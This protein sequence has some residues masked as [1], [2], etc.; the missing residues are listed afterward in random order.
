MAGAK[1]I[2]LDH[3]P[4]EAWTIQPLRGRETTSSTPSTRYEGRVPPEPRRERFPD[5]ESYEEA[6]GYW[7]SHYGRLQA[8]TLK[9]SRPRRDP[10]RG[11]RLDQPIE[12]HSN[13]V[14]QGLAER[15]ARR[16]GI[17]FT[18]IRVYVKVNPRTAEYVVV[19]A[20]LLHGSPVTA[21]AV[22]GEGVERWR[23][24]RASPASDPRSAK[25]SPVGG[26]RD[27]G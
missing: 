18:P 27:R 5:L 21:R 24:P 9:T 25:R 12:W 2:K 8:T 26:G 23:A 3:T 16:S 1:L 19:H 6:L 4:D 17:E 22:R 10:R 13:G 11:C 20:S 14:L 7:R 15:H